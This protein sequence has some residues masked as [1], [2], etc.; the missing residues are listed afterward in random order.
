MAFV[1][2]IEELVAL[3]GI[4][5][6][7][8]DVR[9]FVGC[10]G[11][12]IVALVLA[13]GMSVEELR[14][15]VASIDLGSVRGSFGLLGDLHRV[16]KSTGAFFGERLMSITDNII[17]E[18]TGVH[19][20]TFHQLRERTGRD[21]VIIATSLRDKRPV[22]FSAELTPDESIAAAVRASCA[23]P[24][25][26][27]RVL[28]VDGDTLVDGALSVPVPI[29]YFDDV[30]GARTLGLYLRVHNQNEKGEDRGGNISTLCKFTTDIIDLLLTPLCEQCVADD[31]DRILVIDVP[32]IGITQMTPTAS[33][34]DELIVCGRTAAKQFK[35]RH[36]IGSGNALLHKV[37]LRL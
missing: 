33:Q 22:H 3:W 12:C 4:E 8:N 36:P 11:G 21:L 23:I 34:R 14:A 37:L 25:V 9:G 1:G 20:M 5:W 2:A 17:F 28:T 32:N 29:R 10:S 18:Q 26:F 16:I 7:H 13:L 6:L 19:S 31:I 15:A 27:D 35:T 24:F 30:A